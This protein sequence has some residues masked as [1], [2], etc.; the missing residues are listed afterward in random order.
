MCIHGMYM[1][2]HFN[3]SQNDFMQNWTGNEK[4]FCKRMS[5]RLTFI[6]PI[7]YSTGN[8]IKRSKKNI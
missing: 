4:R 7:V 6:M 2:T 8:V 3:S 1:S 5:V